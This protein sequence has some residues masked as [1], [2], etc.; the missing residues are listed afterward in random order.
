MVRAEILDAFR[1]QIGGC[2]KAG[3]ELTARLMER[4]VAELESGGPLARLLEDWRGQPLLARPG[5][6]IASA[7]FAD[8]SF[9]CQAGPPPFHRRRGPSSAIGA[10]GLTDGTAVPARDGDPVDSHA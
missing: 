10:G 3:S 9:N 6:T 8:G 4:C 2:R 5:E 1:A 7:L